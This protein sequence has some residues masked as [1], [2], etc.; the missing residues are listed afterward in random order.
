MSAQPLIRTPEERSAP[1]TVVGTSV[2]LLATAAETGGQEFTLQAGSEGQGPP[3]HSHVW[4]EAFFV[5]EGTIEFTCGEVTRAC[6]SGSLVFVPAGTVH[7]FRYGPEGGKMLEMT[8]A[9]SRA[10][11]LFGDLATR[12]APGP[13]DVAAVAEIFEEHDAR[14][15]VGADGGE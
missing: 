3:P 15:H 4:P 13:L 14:V 7:S 6:G 9:G 2:T 12:L 5:L 11:G 10:S 1:I 8:G